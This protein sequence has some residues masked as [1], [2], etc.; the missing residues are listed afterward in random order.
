MQIKR[1]HCEAWDKA[2]AELETFFA[3]ATLPKELNTPTGRIT[4]VPLF[5]ETHLQY[6]RAN[7]NNKTFLPYAERLRELQNILKHGTE[8]I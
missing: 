3:A 7:N 2:V 4:D 5:V 8:R 1:R 6:V